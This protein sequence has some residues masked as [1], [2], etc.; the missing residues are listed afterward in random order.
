MFQAD[1]HNPCAQEHQG[2]RPKLLS[3]RSTHVC[4]HEVHWMSGHGSHHHHYPR[5]PR[6]TTICIPPQQMHRWCNLYCT[7]H[8]PFPTWLKEHQCENKY[9]QIP[10][11]KQS[12]QP[13]SLVFFK[14]Y[15]QKARGALQ[16]SDII[17]KRSMCLVSP[18]DK[19][20]QGWPGMFSW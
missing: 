11:I 10:Y 18:P 6:L 8:W 4:R 5:N 12:R 7:P 9:L 15:L 14:M 1:H 2:N 3:T 19:R 17:Y 20:Q 13:H 16:H